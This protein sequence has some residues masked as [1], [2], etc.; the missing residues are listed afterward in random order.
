M[1]TF[2]AQITVKISYDEMPFMD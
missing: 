2:R 1:F